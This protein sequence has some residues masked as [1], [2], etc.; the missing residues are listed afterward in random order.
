MSNR[1]TEDI[2]LDA[3]HAQK[4]HLKFTAVTADYEYLS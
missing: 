1:F 4:L 2:A 3:L